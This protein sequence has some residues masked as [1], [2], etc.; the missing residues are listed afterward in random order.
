MKK[1][2]SRF[3]VVGSEAL[4][5]ARVGYWCCGDQVAGR[6]LNCRKGWI[7][8]GRRFGIERPFEGAGVGNWWRGM[9]KRTDLRRP[10]E[11]GK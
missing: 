3:K 10:Q 6:N 9:T 8:E 7:R 11:K 2:S 1:A 5:K 4:K